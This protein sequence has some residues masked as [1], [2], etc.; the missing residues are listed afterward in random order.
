MRFHTQIPY[1]K[2]QLQ[3]LLVKIFEIINSN[4]AEQLKIN[5]N[6]IFSNIKDSMGK[7]DNPLIFDMSTEDIQKKIEQYLPVREYEKDTLGEVFTPEKLIV[8][9]LDQ[10]PSSV[11][12]DPSKKWLDPANGTGNF[13]MVVFKK[14]VEKL[15]G[16]YKGSGPEDSY[17]TEEG[18]KR[19]I[20]KNMLYMCEIN[21]KNIKISK[22]IFGPTAN[23][24][25]CDFLNEEKKW[26]KQFKMEKETDKFDIIIGNPPFNDKTNE[27]NRTNKALWPL[28]IDK[29][30]EVLKPGGFLGFIH[31]QNWRGPGQKKWQLLSG[32]Q[33]IYLHI[34]GEKES[35]NL[36]N[37]GTKV[38]LYV[39]QN[40]PNTQ[41]TTVIDAIGD[42]HE[43][44][45]KK[46]LFLPNY[47]ISEISK[48]T[49]NDKGIKVIQ[50]TFYSTVKT[51]ETEK[52]YKVISS[53]VS[54]TVPK[55]RYTDDNTK[56]HFGVSKVI[57]NSGRYP[58]PYND[59]KGEYGMTQ[60]LFAIP[61]TSKKE[62]DCIVEAINSEKFQEIIK[63]SKWGIYGLDYRMFEHLK[64]D[65]YK[66]FVNKSSSC[67]LAKSKKSETKKKRELIIESSTS[68]DT[69]KKEGGFKQSK[70]RTRKNK[71]SIWKIW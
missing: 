53:I 56:G 37:V 63:A 46:Y 32:K 21:P 14:L 24:C 65:F 42:K 60:N 52:Q 59:Y 2:I 29:S 44:D 23:I 51:S 61:I 31:P 12:R 18:K 4:G 33:I 67:S 45:L 17:S 50:D 6:I 41:K 54:G 30:L 58:Y 7:N 66:D 3:R 49:T 19:H 57:I 13:P 69:E 40:K 35:Y 39:L 48:L 20:L 11:W 27:N 22:K 1:T 55:F 70:K 28:F 26:R 47:K 64:P 25:C 62:G 5:L 10:L 15:P 9:M 8:E 34:F 36:F 16:K 68:S 71:K 43:L 38:D